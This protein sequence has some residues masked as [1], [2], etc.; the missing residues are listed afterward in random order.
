ML[1]SHCIHTKMFMSH[2]WPVFQGWNFWQA[3]VITIGEWAKDWKGGVTA[4]GRAIS[5]LERDS[6][7]RKLS[8]C[9]QS[10]GPYLKRCLWPVVDTSCSACLSPTCCSLLIIA[11][12]KLEGCTLLSMGLGAEGWVSFSCWQPC[13]SAG[14][15]LPESAP[16]L[17]KGRTQTER[18]RLDLK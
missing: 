12:V 1:I 3:G 4:E 2:L 15:G 6:V 11:R 10:G 14:Q 16:R 9:P 13:A 7:L 8:T 5:S 18:N 17:E